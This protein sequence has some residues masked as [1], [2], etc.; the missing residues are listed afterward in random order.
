MRD[1]AHVNQVAA[2][3]QDLETR[4]ATAA[5]A[6]AARVLVAVASE[7]AAL[8]RQLTEAG[9][10]PQ[11][12]TPTL[13]KYVT[14]LRYEIIQGKV[15]SLTIALPANHA[16]T[17]LT[18]DQIRDWE[19]KPVAEGAGAQAERAQVLEVKFIKPIEKK[20][21]IMVY[22]EQTLESMP[23]TVVLASPQPLEVEREETGE[24]VHAGEPSLRTQGP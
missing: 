19:I 8:D 5:S 22:S 7:L 4:T 2:L 18:G 10:A 21:E 16:L 3:Q 6:E 9:M 15:A 1:K 17:R 24:C 13:V 12:I 11:A 14:Q 20:C 23:A